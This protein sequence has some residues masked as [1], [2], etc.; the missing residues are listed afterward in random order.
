MQDDSSRGASSGS[1]RFALY[2]SAN[3]AVLWLLFAA[4]YSPHEW[5]VGFIVLVA[6]TAFALFLRRYK[7]VDAHLAMRDVAQ[8][9]RLPWYLLVDCWTILVVLAR[10]LFGSRR[11]ESFFRV[12]HFGKPGAAAEPAELGR[13]ILATIYTTATPNSIVIGADQHRLLFHQVAMTPVE[14]TT[15]DLGARP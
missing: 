15:R 3:A 10:D 4:S 7:P 11:P 1:L 12:C 14:Q 5:L 13:L 9:W 2:A 8:G 6:A